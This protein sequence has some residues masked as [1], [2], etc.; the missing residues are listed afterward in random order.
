MQGQESSSQRRRSGQ[1]TTARVH[2]DDVVQVWH[3]SV[4]TFWIL[5]THALYL[6]SFVLLGLDT[7]VK[8]AVEWHLVK[9]ELAGESPLNGLACMQALLLSIRAPSP[10]EVFNVV[11]DD[12]SSRATAMA[13]A[14]GL[15]DVE[16]PAQPESAATSSTQARGEKKVSNRKAKEVL[17]WQPRFP[18]YREGLR[19][20]FEQE[21]FTSV[22]RLNGKE[23]PDTTLV[24]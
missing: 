3:R 24:G 9:G 20:V 21:T 7:D 19:S 12:C 18:S 10:G 4:Q 8:L 2:V 22:L 11:D 1:A 17:G 16:L 5:C 23:D 6:C 13:F 15:L 14:A